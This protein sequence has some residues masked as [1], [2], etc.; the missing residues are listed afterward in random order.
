MHKADD[1]LSFVH[2]YS[3]LQPESKLSP[4]VWS[5]AVP[6]ACSRCSIVGICTT[7]QASYRGLMFLMSLRRGQCT[8]KLC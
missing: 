6:E 3:I 4:S 7:R 5:L 8:P 1:A 2:P